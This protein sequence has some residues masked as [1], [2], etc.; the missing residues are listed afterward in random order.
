MQHR[1]IIRRY[2]NYDFTVE[3]KKRES[4]FALFSFRV[5]IAVI[6]YDFHHDVHLVIKKQLE[7]R[8]KTREAIRVPFITDLQ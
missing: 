5:F 7:Q 4:C 2:V 3:E 1:I 6:Y 8:E